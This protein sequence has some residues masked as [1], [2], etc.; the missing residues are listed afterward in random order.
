MRRKR[1]IDDM[2]DLRSVKR[3]IICAIALA[4][5]SLV[6]GLF[7]N[8]EGD[9]AELGLLLCIIF[10]AAAVALWIGYWKCP[11]CGKHLD[12]IGRAHV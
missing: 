3:Y 11:Y 7:T 6:P 10:V 4:I 8:G 12:K 2:K 1:W 5:F 9:L